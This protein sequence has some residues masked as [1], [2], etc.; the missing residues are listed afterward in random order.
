MGAVRDAHAAATRDKLV[1]VARRMFQHD[2]YD[3][4]TIREVSK[5]AGYSTGAVYTHFKDKAAM[6]EEAMG[7]PAP[8]M[9]AFL[10]E[11]IATARAGDERVLFAQLRERAVV[12]RGHLKGHHA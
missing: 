11:V 6:F 12:L 4:V 5:A 8:D 9:I 3:E 7:E 1:T 2:G 10:D